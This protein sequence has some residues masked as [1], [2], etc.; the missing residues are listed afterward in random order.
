MLI[1]PKHLQNATR[2]TAFK[3]GVYLSSQHIC[4]GPDVMELLGVDTQNVFLAYYPDRQQLLISPVSNAFFIKLHKASQHIM[5]H[6]DKHGTK[7]IAIHELLID[8]IGE[9]AE[10]ELAFSFQPQSGLLKITL[11]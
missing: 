7:A 3:K 9:V 11:G 6:R 8:K 1:P 2:E 10:G 4:L 5:K